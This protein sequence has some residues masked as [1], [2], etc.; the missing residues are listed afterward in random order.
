MNEQAREVQARVEQAYEAYKAAHARASA[1]PADSQ[2]REA[3]TQ[4]EKHYRVSR[5]R[6]EAQLKALARGAGTSRAS[7]LPG[8][9]ASPAP[10]REPRPHRRGRELSNRT[11]LPP[12]PPA[13]LPQGEPAQ[14]EPREPR[15]RA[16]TLPATRAPQR[17]P[18]RRAGEPPA[19]ARARPSGNNLHLSGWRLAAA[20]AD[21]MVVSIP[22]VLL[23]AAGLSLALRGASGPAVVLAVIVL[24]LFSWG[25]YSLSTMLRARHPGQ[26]WGKQLCRLQARARS[27]EPL[28]AGGLLARELLAKP[29]LFGLVFLL[30]ALWLPLSILAGLGIAV[31]LWKDLAPHDRV[32]GSQ[33]VMLPPPAEE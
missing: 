14:S 18:A 15:S 20:L 5:A 9:P 26:T 6:G 13:P 19:E 2:L 31:L 12:E 1:A 32:C 7:A 27:G 33:V 24:S 28:Q 3:L 17:R 8:A 30:G 29:A 16:D 22:S 10:E 4:A 25:V 23:L 21:L 11:P